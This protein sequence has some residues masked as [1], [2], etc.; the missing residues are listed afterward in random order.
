MAD[1]PYMISV[2][3]TLHLADSSKTLSDV[4]I[5][6]SGYHRK[7][8]AALTLCLISS[9]DKTALA[10]ECIADCANVSLGE[11]TS[12][13]P[14]LISACYMRHVLCLYS[15]VWVM[16]LDGAESQIVIFHHCSVVWRVR[17]GGVR[18]IYCNV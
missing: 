16:S 18:F 1:A 5:T 15:V 17:E 2:C 14:S 6:D 9:T 4:A 11:P 8:P 12:P 10:A 7:L 3:V 13:S